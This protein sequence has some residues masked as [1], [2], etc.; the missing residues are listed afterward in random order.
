M[1]RCAL[2]RRT[3][4]HERILK[5]EEDVGEGLI[6]RVIALEIEV[7]SRKSDDGYQWSTLAEFRQRI[8]AL[9]GKK[10]EA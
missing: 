4:R 2:E 1:K 9:E 8:M 6:K 3:E 7:R 5:G 10:E